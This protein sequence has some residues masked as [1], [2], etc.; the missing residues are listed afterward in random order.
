VATVGARGV[1]STGTAT[2]D[3]G[4]RVKVKTIAVHW[5][6]DLPSSSSVETS[7]DGSSWTPA[8][9]DSSGKLRNP[10]TA[11]YVRVTVTRADAKLRGVRELVVTG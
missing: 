5:T 11:R 6:K 4:R 7:L 3:L 2:V 8:S 10:V 1:A 9:P